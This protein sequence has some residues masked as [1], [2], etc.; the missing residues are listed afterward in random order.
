MARSFQW[1]NVNINFRRNR[2]FQKLKSGMHKEIHGSNG[3][4]IRNFVPN[5]GK[6][7][8]GYYILYFFLQTNKQK[9]ISCHFLAMSLSLEKE[10]CVGFQ[11]VYFLSF[12]TYIAT[13]VTALRFTL[14]CHRHHTSFC[15]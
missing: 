12:P 5:D 4:L 7:A 2:L 10:L 14:K 11:G 8:R 13:T 1:H 3:D 6:Y 15:E 9:P